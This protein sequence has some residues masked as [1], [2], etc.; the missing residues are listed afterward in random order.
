MR[1]NLNLPINGAATF[2]ISNRIFRIVWITSWFVLA[3]PTPAFL[4]SWRRIL[5]RLFGADIHATAKIYS[6]VEIWDPRNLVMG[7]HSC[8]GPKVVCYNMASITL[9]Q[10]AVVSQGAHLCCGSHNIDSDEF[11]LVVR[12]IRICAKAWVAAEAFV[13]PG[14]IVSQGA[15]L[16]ARAVAV[17]TIDAW[18]VY[19]GNP[20]KCIRKRYST[21]TLP[22]STS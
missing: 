1:P 17:G 12:P 22:S 5:L 8:L 13:G 10:Y 18:C 16:G 6:S 7:P 4:H 11:E 15:V 19:A 2:P 9:E 3:R 21:A 20:A 14:V